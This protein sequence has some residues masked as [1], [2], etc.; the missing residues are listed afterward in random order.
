[1]CLVQLDDRKS[2]LAPA[3]IFQAMD[4]TAFAFDQAAVALEHGRDL[5]ALVRVDQETDFIMSHFHS[6]WISQPGQQAWTVKA[7]PDS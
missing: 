5:L 1:M 7:S 2:Q 6:S 3:P 4:V